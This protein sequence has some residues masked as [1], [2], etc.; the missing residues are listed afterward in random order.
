M[1]V[2]SV[3]TEAQLNDMLATYANSLDPMAL[4]MIEAINVEL[5]CRLV[6]NER[7]TFRRFVG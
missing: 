5:H 3:M 4:D 7:K 1:I 6:T 2:F